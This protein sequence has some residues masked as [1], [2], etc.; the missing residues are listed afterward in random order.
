MSFIP[1]IE[2]QSIESIQSYQ[3][4]ELQKLVQYLIIHSPFY[5]KHFTQN[6]IQ[7]DSI[8]RI[9]DLQ[10]IP[11]IGKEEL[12]KHNWDFLCVPKNRIAEYT[13]TS[14]TLGKPVTIALTENDLK[15]LGYNEHISFACADGEAGDI[16]QLLLTLDRQFM[17]GIAYYEGIR[18]LGA[19]AIRIGP[20]LPALQWNS[21]EQLKPTI[22]VAVPSFIIKLLDYADTHSIDYLKSSV[23]KIVCIGEGIRN[24]EFELNTIGRGIKERWA[25]D[26]YSTYASTEMQTAFTEC[27]NGKGGHLHPELLIVEFLDNNNEPVTQGELGEVTITT[28]GVEGM[29]LLRYKTGDMVRHYTEP[30]LCGRNTLRLGVVEGRKQHLIKL[31]G[32]TIYPSS[33]FEVLHQVKEIKDYI[34]EV[35]TG[36]LGTDDVKLHLALI[37]EPDV[38]L[39]YSIK[40]F[41]K[42]G[43]RVLPEIIFYSGEELEKL[44][45]KG[46]LRKPKKFIDNRDTSG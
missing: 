43:L 42:S 29:P 4:K 41:I 15:R 36:L 23:Q 33:I 16:Y 35:S 32:T 26:L 11:A 17:A 44:Q 46:Q 21:I 1:K 25:V 45:M 3:E 8:H 13:S 20:G 30:C 9:R 6:N 27:S 18:Q 2:V 39:T 14:G 31:H 10:K 7:T 28:L 5:K 12:Q 37:T 19:A 22:L 40:S 24:Q 38:Q 34:V